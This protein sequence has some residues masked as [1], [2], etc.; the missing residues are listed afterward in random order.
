MPQYRVGRVFLAGDAA[1]CHS[2]T[3]GQGTNT[4]M[5]DAVLVGTD[6]LTV[7][8]PSQV[9][10]VVPGRPIAAL[11]LVRPDGYVAWAGTATQFPTWA[12]EYFRRRS[13][14]RTPDELPVR[15]G[16]DWRTPLPAK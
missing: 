7:D 11:V 6:A 2:P 16:S 12:H 3:G 1:H 14:F 15:S 13:N 4:G 8:L 5:Q 9:T 10:A